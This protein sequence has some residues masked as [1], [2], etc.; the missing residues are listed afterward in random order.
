LKNRTNIG[1]IASIIRCAANQW[2]YQ[3]TIMNKASVSHSQ[4]T[5]YLR[6]AVKQGLM[7]YSKVTGLYKTTSIGADFLEKH[8]KLVRLFPEIAEPTKYI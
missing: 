1:I 7:E 8:D 5:R 6:L 2:E 3:T 4:I